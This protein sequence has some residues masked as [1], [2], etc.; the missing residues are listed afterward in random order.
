MAHVQIIKHKKGFVKQQV[1][2]EPDRSRT[3]INN[4][5]EAWHNY[6]LSLYYEVVKIQPPA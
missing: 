1:T 5:I 6:L 4:F 3:N 2:F